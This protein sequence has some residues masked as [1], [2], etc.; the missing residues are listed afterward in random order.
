ML[1]VLHQCELLA[2]MDNRMQS[3]GKW[4]ACTSDR[5]GHSNLY[6]KPSDGSGGRTSSHRGAG[7]RSHRL[8]A[9]WQDVALF[10]RPCAIQEQVGN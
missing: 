8:V 10:A 9:G 6:R 4:I 3:H 2:V 5:N 7:D 1:S